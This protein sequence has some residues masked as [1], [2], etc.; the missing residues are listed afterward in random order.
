MARRDKSK[1][2]APSVRSCSVCTSTRVQTRYEGRYTIKNRRID[3]SSCT[4]L[5]CGAAWHEDYM[6]RAQEVINRP[7]GARAQIDQQLNQDTPAEKSAV[8]NI[9]RGA[10]TSRLCPVCGSD[11][12]SAGFNGSVTINGQRIDKAT[13]GCHICASLWSEA[14]NRRTGE[15]SVSDIRPEAMKAALKADQQHAA[16]MTSGTPAD[17]DACPVCTAA[18]I[19]ISTEARG[20]ITRRN[21]PVREGVCTCGQ[22]SAQWVERW[23]TL[24]K[25]TRRYDLRKPVTDAFS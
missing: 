22:C 23:F 16:P 11:E 21:Q 7:M 8:Q 6:V 20:T 18:R 13:A 3:Q 19:H 9:K 10:D 14:Y 4:C 15:T 5:E 2:A 17:A 12:T 1:S 25:V 24:D